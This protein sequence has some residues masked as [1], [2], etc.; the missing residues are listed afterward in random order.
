M[1]EEITDVQCPSCFEWFSFTLPPE[2][3]RVGEV[4]YDCEVCCR[5]MMIVFSAEGACA[6]SI[7]D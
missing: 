1:L 7:E 2:E 4:D 3:E 5:P 6:V